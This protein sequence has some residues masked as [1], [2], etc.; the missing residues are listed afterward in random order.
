M[1]QLNSAEQSTVLI[2]IVVVFTYAVWALTRRLAA[3]PREPDPWGDE[4]TA[5]LETG[6]GTPLCH[7]CLAEHD[8]SA[9]FC[10]QCG[11]AV[12]LYTNLMPY[13]R[14]FSIGHTFRIGTNE[15]FKRS[16]V[17]VGGFFVLSIFEYGIFFPVYWFRLIQNLSRIPPLPLEPLESSAGTPSDGPTAP[18]A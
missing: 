15:N 6:E 7:H 3:G 11:A 4:I 16:I 10:P 14:L 5:E 1:K 18:T 8:P 9:D 13:P 12:G 17:T 2:G